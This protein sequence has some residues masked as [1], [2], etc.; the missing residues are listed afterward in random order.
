MKKTV[1]LTAAAVALSVG[2]FS[3][4]V[5][6]NQADRRAAMKQIAGA[7]KGMGTGTME[8]GVAGQTIVD[9]AAQIPTL[10]MENEITGDSTSKPEIWV[11]Y[12]DFVAK[13]SDLEAAA[14]ALVDAVNNG[15]DV[16]AAGKAVGATCGACHKLYK[17]S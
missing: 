4:S 16:A 11:N 6:A 3:V 14:K 8:P 10:F 12:D 5:E 1:I 17:A 2:T 7:M 9:L 15:G 13:G